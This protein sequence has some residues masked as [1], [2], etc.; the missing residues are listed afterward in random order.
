MVNDRSHLMMLQEVI[1]KTLL[2]LSLWRTNKVADKMREN[3]VPSQ[4]K[5]DLDVGATID[6]EI[7]F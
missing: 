5:T 2:I 6:D 1:Y 7:P 3:M 4:V